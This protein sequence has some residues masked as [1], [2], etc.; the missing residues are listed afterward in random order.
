[1]AGNRERFFSEVLYRLD[2]YQVLNDLRQW[3]VDDTVGLLCWERTPLTPDNWCHRTM[4]A[5]WF[6]DY[7]IEVQEWSGGKELNPAQAR[8]DI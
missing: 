4:V 1:M 3:A 7:G 8:L 6:S 2:P 5:E